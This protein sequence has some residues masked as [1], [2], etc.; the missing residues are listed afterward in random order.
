VYDIISGELTNKY[1]RISELLEEAKSIAKLKGDKDT[2]RKN[3]NV[4]VLKEIGLN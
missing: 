4:S 2:Q 1:T 3:L